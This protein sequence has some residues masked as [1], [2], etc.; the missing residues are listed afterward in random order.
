VPA[1]LL[2]GLL[3]AGDLH[4]LRA[5]ARARV[6][7]RV[8]SVDRKPAAVAQTA[9]AADL[10]QALDVL[11]DLAPE[12]AFDGQVLVD[13]VTKLRDLVLREVADVGVSLLDCGRPTP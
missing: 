7:F 6:G 12:V 1:L 9:V 13:R 11:G 3:L 4:A 8:L 10:R 5:L 2:T